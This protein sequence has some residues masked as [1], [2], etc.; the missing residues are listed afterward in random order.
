M[1]LPFVGKL[2]SEK[3]TKA[4]VLG[5]IIAV[6]GAAVMSTSEMIEDA[7]GLNE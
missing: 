1:I 6:A 3:L 4:A 7:I 2:Y 5:A